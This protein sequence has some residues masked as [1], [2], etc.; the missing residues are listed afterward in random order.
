MPGAVGLGYIGKAR[1]SSP[2]LSLIRCFLSPFGHSDLRE[3][4]VGFCLGATLCDCP[5]STQHDLASPRKNLSGCPNQVG[6]WA[7]LWVVLI[8]VGVSSLKTGSNILQ[9]WIMGCAE[10]ERAK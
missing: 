1:S 3:I 7:G 8:G 2:P 6:L 4:D 5:F 10:G 9:A